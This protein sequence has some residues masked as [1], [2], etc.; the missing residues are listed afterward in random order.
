MHNGRDFAYQRIV[1]CQALQHTLPFLLALFAFSASTRS[2]LS[3]GTG[4]LQYAARNR[5]KGWSD[6]GFSVNGDLIHH[7]N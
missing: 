3:A 2:V 4:A 1:R 7:S 5:A 6:C